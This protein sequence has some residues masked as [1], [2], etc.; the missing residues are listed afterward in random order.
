MVRALPHDS[1]RY[2]VIGGELLVTPA[3]SATH[4]RAVIGLLVRLANYLE[5]EPCGEVLASPADISFHADMLVQPDLFVLPITPDEGRVLGW[6]QIRT[7]LLAVEVLLAPTARADRQVKRRLYQQE[8]V[9]EYWIVDVN[10]RLVERWRAGDEHPEI[11][12]A[13]LSWHPEP[14]SAPFELDLAAFFDEVLRERW[15]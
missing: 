10:A 12:S 6:S 14:A 4:Q 9:G 7:L 3:P 15:R 1:Y 8:P 2:E 13:T 5:H 11:L